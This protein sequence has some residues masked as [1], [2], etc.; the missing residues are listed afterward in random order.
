MHNDPIDVQESADTF[1]NALKLIKM[2]RIK[3]GCEK[4]GQTLSSAQFGT[5]YGLLKDIFQKKFMKSRALLA[6]DPDTLTGKEKKKCKNDERGA[7][8]IIKTKVLIPYYF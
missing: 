2:M 8:S 4:D 3:V 5:A 7:K 1:A 6:T